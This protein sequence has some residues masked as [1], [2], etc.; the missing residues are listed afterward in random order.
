MWEICKFYFGN[1][2]DL[3]LLEEYENSREYQ[4][5][6]CL[7]INLRSVYFIFKL[8]H[9]LRTHGSKEIHQVTIRIPE[10]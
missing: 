7:Q 9:C 10:Q 5:R 1:V 4:T 3:A 6:D 8:L 2:S